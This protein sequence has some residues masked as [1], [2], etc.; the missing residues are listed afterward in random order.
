MSLFLQ[1]A[2]DAEIGKCL[3]NVGVAAGDSRYTKWVSNFIKTLKLKKYYLYRDELARGRFWPFTPDNHLKPGKKDPNFWWVANLSHH[4]RLYD[5]W[6]TFI[7]TGTGKT[8]TTRLS[9]VQT[10]VLIQSYHSTM[11]PQ[12]RCMCTST[13]FIVLGTDSVKV[14]KKKRIITSLGAILGRKMSQRNL[15]TCDK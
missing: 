10:V 1:G 12:P 3:M 6:I 8:C 5:I 4:V 13:W 11:F 9:R 15:S 7:M 14:A 2:E